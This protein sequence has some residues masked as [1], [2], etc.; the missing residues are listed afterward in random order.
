MNKSEIRN[1]RPKQLV[2]NG[3]Q[4]NYNTSEIQRAFTELAVAQQN[5]D[6]IPREPSRLDRR[7]EFSWYIFAMMSER[8]TCERGRFTAVRIRAVDAVGKTCLSHD[9][10]LRE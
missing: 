2:T 4:P 6:S 1:R 10:T 5:L 7:G 9:V 8:A 3:L